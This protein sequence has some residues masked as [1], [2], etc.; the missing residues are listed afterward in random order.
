[1][2]EHGDDQSTAADRGLDI[3]SDYRDV[4]AEFPSEGDGTQ[5]GSNQRRPDGVPGNLENDGPCGDMRDLLQNLS[6]NMGQ[7]TRVLQDVVA[8]LIKKDDQGNKAGE[9]IR[10]DMC[11]NLNGNYPLQTQSCGKC[12]LRDKN[13][14]NMV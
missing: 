2:E 1:M 14:G 12:N 11:D 3:R 9:G 8:V 5:R 10:R 13:R 7:F 4:G 6:R